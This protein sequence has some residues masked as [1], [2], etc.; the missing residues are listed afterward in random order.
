MPAV[1]TSNMM[2]AVRIREAVSEDLAL[3]DSANRFFDEIEGYPE[4]AIAIDF[5]GIRSISRSFAH[6]YM[7]RKH[8]STKSISE[9][10]VPQNV[11]SMFRV[12]SEPAPKPRLV[13]E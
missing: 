7:T 5:R 2:K 4:A 11:N 12:V 6:Q 13:V 9:A 1:V 8:Q 10:N 3:R